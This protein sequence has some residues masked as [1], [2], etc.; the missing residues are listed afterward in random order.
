MIRI[1]IACRFLENAQNP[2]G[3]WGYRPGSH[4]TVEPTGRGPPRPAGHGLPEKAP[5][6]RP[7]D[8]PA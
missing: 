5:A 7:V 4:P 1:A 6:I 8:S 2:D 3:G